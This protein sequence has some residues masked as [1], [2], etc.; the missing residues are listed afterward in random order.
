[1]TY[2]IELVNM[3]IKLPSIKL[4]M[5]VAVVIQCSQGAAL[6]TQAEQ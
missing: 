6:Y 4:L 3:S 2:I 5:Q 1:M